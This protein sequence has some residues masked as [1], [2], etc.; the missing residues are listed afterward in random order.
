MTKSQHPD[1]KRGGG[2]NP[3][4]QPDRKKTV[5]FLDDFPKCPCKCWVISDFHQGS[6]AAHLLPGHKGGQDVHLLLLTAIHLNG[7]GDGDTSGWS[8][9]KD[10]PTLIGPMKMLLWAVM[11][12]PVPA[13]PRLSVL[14]TISLNFKSKDRYL[15]YPEIRDGNLPDLFH[16]DGIRESVLACSAILTL[17]INNQ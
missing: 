11:M 2:V 1:R 6:A 15:L 13:Q 10:A 8:T 4:G 12:V 14:S 5:F 7:D 3:Y 16:S 9:L 17:D